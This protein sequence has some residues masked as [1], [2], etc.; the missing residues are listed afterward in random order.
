MNGIE[1]SIIDI[2]VVQSLN[3]G[4]IYRSMSRAGNVALRVLAVLYLVYLL[5]R[6]RL[7]VRHCR[8]RYYY[9]SC[10]LSRCILRM[11]PKH[12]PMGL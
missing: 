12:L 1:H 7:Y 5:L 10:A 9:Y 3:W 2:H 11:S 4:I 8:C 6:I